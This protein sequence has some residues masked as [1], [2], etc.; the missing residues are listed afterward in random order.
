MSE[1]RNRRRGKRKPSQPRRGGSSTT[2][3]TR[4]VGAR[5][6]ESTRL[7]RI[8]P[9][10][11]RKIRRWGFFAAAGLIAVVIIGSFALSSFP[12]GFGGGGGPTST[13]EGVGRSVSVM[14]SA[15]HISNPN[16]TVEYST[17]PPTS[18]NH[19]FTPSDCGI[20]DAELADERVVHNMEHG[21]VIISYNLSDPG[22][23]GRLIDVA[24]GLSQLGMW[25]I[26][27][28]Y[29]KIE[30]GTVAMTAWGVIDEA[31]GVDEDRIREFYNTYANNRLSPETQQV[32]PIPCT[33]T[34]HSGG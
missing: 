13:V 14:P 32:G 12:R 23:V 4:R 31:Q 10:M 7:L 28:P 34:T 25:G 30:P 24:E 1:P 26:V 21:H 19:W 16:E 2:P 11:W 8:R 9:R 17:T 29:S 27:R 3:S 6:A 15:S 33:S 5:P 18:G 20:Y 22:E